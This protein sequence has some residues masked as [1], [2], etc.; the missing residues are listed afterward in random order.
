MALINVT[1]LRR[2]VHICASCHHVALLIEVL[3]QHL[4]QLALLVLAR[5]QGK[6]LEPG[7]V[8]LLRLQTKL[9]CVARCDVRVA[10]QLFLADDDGRAAA[11]EP[12]VM[13]G[14]FWVQDDSTEFKLALA[15]RV[16]LRY[17]A[18]VN[19]TLVVVGEAG[20]LFVLKARSGSTVVVGR[21]IVR[22]E[23]LDLEVRLLL[24]SN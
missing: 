16:E 17:V 9:S 19:Q 7:C 24:S 15:R 22:A 1:L 8:R 3:A 12:L 10:P 13:F 6:R 11:S 21:W 23:L 2:L 14:Q 4:R 5:R 18:A 20:A